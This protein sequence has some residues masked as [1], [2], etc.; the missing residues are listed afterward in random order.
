[1]LGVDSVLHNGGKLVHPAADTPADL[2]LDGGPLPP[3]EAPPALVALLKSRIDYARSAYCIDGLEAWNCTTCHA[4]ATSGTTAVAT[5]GSPQAMFGFAAAHPASRTVVVGLRGTR[6]LDNWIKD[7][8]VARPDAPFDGSPDGSR[9]HLGFL[10]AWE[11]I[12][13]DTLTAVDA[14]LARFPGFD[15]LVTGH[16]L[17]GAVA[18]LAAADL[19][20]SGFV[21]ADRIMVLAINA[22]R[23]GNG[24]F[25]KWFAMLPLK[26]VWRIVNQNDLTPHLPPQFVGFAHHPTELW[27]ADASGHTVVCPVS[28]DDDEL[29]GIGLPENDLRDV[30][31]AIDAQDWTQFRDL[32]G[33]AR[34][35]ESRD[36]ANSVTRG[37]DLQKHTWVW[38]LRIGIRGC[39]PPDDGS[40]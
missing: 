16:S 25:A 2:P 34:A 8:M 28:L 36:C 30:E 39:D 32:P 5:L 29:D 31:A 4:A 40:S 1:M 10:R 35:P 14:L 6:N 11:S 22:P 38:D 17:G 20:S 9:V 33:I 23:T 19:A 37:Y 27:I 21:A 12:R 26:A 13:N 15:V 18:T 3:Q 7:L 24:V